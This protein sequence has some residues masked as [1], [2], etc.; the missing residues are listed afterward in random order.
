MI[1]NS[2]P[3]VAESYTA[4][5]TQFMSTC[6][7]CSSCVCSSASWK[8]TCWWTG[9]DRYKTWW[10]MTVEI[11]GSMKKGRWVLRGDTA[12]KAIKNQV[13][14][15]LATSKKVLFPSHSHLLNI[16]TN[17]PTLWLL[18]QRQH[19]RYLVVVTWLFRKVRESVCE[20]ER[21]WKRGGGR[22]NGDVKNLIVRL[23]QNPFHE[24]NQL[25]HDMLLLWPCI[26]HDLWL[27]LHSSTVYAVTSEKI[28]IW[29]YLRVLITYNVNTWLLSI[30]AHCQLTIHKYIYKCFLV[31]A[32]A[33]SLAVDP[34]QLC[35]CG[36]LY[37]DLREGP[38]PQYAHLCD[39]VLRR[40]A[41]W[42]TS[43]WD[44]VSMSNSMT[45]YIRRIIIFK[46][47]YF[48][49]WN[50]IPQTV[51]LFFHFINI[52]WRQV[53]YYSCEMT[54]STLYYTPCIYVQ[55]CLTWILSWVI[56]V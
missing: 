44:G 1:Y 35:Y 25:Q 13:T 21:Q 22:G 26:Q 45:G 5:G 23:Q 2:L 24:G 48:T 50:V 8:T 42:A 40:R 37:V 34:L 39:S 27:T 32:P 41:S 6:L 18:P 56:R 17:N 30:L 15:M 29:N 9:W 20:N 47:G 31:S 55:F 33:V 4:R 53:N 16:G 28:T 36:Q 51:F 46:Q 49:Q 7:Y 43:L 3:F 11:H 12:Q 19:G 54:F 52:G 10:K 38:V 14:T